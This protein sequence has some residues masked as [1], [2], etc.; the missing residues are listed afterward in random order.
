MGE[1]AA[2]PRRNPIHLRHPCSNNLSERVAMVNAVEEFDEPRRRPGGRRRRRRMPSCMP[3]TIAATV[4]FEMMAAQ[5]SASTPSRS[6]PANDSRHAPLYWPTARPRWP[7]RRARPSGRTRE[8]WGRPAHG[9]EGLHT[10]PEPLAHLPGRADDRGDEVE[11]RPAERDGRP[12]RTARPWRGNR[13]RRC[14][15]A[16]PRHG[17]RRA[18]RAPGGGVTVRGD[19]RIKPSRRLL[20]TYTPCPRRRIATALSAAPCHDTGSI[21]VR[22]V[23]SGP[24]QP[25]QRCASGDVLHAMMAEAIDV[26]A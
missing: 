10:G 8:P 4:I 24:A 21:T 2:P 23:V 16:T 5:S 26:D 22:P 12:R 9:V 19:L 20:R 25:H 18:G 6:S 14:P 1:A 3:P 13:G 7:G 17:G 15:V 11:P